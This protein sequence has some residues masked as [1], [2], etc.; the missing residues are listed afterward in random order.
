MYVAT[1]LRE[2]HMESQ[3]D[4]SR[5]ESDAAHPHFPHAIRLFPGGMWLIMVAP[6]QHGPR[7]VPSEVWSTRQDETILREEKSRGYRRHR[8]S[9]YTDL[10]I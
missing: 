2:D 4:A 5:V 7:P 3:L 10:C 8:H 1:R 6:D 9:F